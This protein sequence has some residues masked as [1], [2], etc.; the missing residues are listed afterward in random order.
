MEA[1]MRAKVKMHDDGS[2]TV[3]IGELGP[4]FQHV[5]PPLGLEIGGEPWGYFTGKPDSLAVEILNI[6]RY[7]VGEYGGESVGGTHAKNMLDA[8]VR[9]KIAQEGEK[10]QNEK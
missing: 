3:G 8:W 9:L 4:E 6:Y 2:F 10:C 1:E 5:H 7:F